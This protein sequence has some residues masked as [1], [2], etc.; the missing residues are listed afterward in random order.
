M[1]IAISALI[2]GTL[3]SLPIKAAWAGGGSI[4]GTVT[5]TSGTSTTT[6]SG[7]ATLPTNMYYPG[8]LTVTYTDN[9]ASGGS[10]NTPSYQ[11]TGLNVSSNS[12]ATVVPT[13]S[14]I[15]SVVANQLQQSFTN[16]NLSTAVS[17]IRA[18]AGSAGLE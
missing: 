16:N 9:T 17:I 8:T 4:S 15:S 12:A 5:Y 14:S 10:P 18:A 6:I 13:G 11:L 2:V 7:Q 3:L 1:R